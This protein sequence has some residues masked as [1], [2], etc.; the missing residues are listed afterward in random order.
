[1]MYGY[2]NDRDM[3]REINHANR[4]MPFTVAPFPAT[5]VKQYLSWNDVLYSVHSQIECMPHLA[6]WADDKV[7]H[8]RGPMPVWLVNQLVA[9]YLQNLNDDELAMVEPLLHYIDNFGFVNNVQG[10]KDSVLL[11]VDICGTRHTLLITVMN[12]MEYENGY[13]HYMRRD[14]IN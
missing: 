10:F 3:E 11:S 2:R 14:S 6:Q 1:M 4:E 8:V 9:P 13:E 5:Y 12:M 7:E